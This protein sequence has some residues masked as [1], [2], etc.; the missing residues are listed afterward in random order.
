MTLRFSFCVMLYVF[1]ACTAKKQNEKPEIEDIP[2]SGLSGKE[3]SIAHCS[4]CHGYVNPELLPKSSWQEVLPAMGHRMGIYS[5][6]S[7][8]DSL[9]DGGTSGARVR[10]AD[11]FPEK[12][13]LA[14]EDWIQLVNYYLDNAPDT[15]PP[16]LRKSPIRIGL[17]H[18]KYKEIAVSHRP[19]LTSLVKILPNRRGIVYGDG[20]SGRNLL[21]FLDAD[22]RE[23]YSLPLQ[24]TP[25]QFYEKDSAIYLTTVGKGV[26]PTDA[27]EGTLQ[28]L[29]KNGAAPGYQPGAV[30]IQYLR[31][32]VSMAYGDLNQDGL[33]D[34]V[35]C[36]FGNQT[37]QLAWYPSNGRGGY[38]NKRILRE[39]PGAITAIV[40]DANRDGLLDIYVL[41]AQGDEGVFLYENQG[42]GTFREKRLLS[43]LPLNGSQYIELADFNKDGFDDIVYVCGDNADKTPIQKNYHGI[44]IYLN[45]GKSN[46][47]QSYFYPLNGAYK[48]MVRDYDL[49][50]DLDIAA[51]SFFPDYL[52]YPE[53]SFIYLQNKGNLKFDDYSFPEAAKGR[54]V[55]MDAGDL[56][57]DGDV[58]LVLGSFVYF[59]PQGDTTGLG[60]KWL[61]TSPSVIVLENTIR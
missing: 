34:V 21:T 27:A 17:K 31:R 60:K 26:F 19:A 23:N 8:P 53:E 24:S 52:R 12:P 43:F 29:T 1:A 6:G 36:E 46:F 14:R 50:G 51:I 13:I 40:K 44:Y 42:K 59:L 16:P 47:T 55:V 15:I 41:M 32:P 61:S 37:G 54:W 7:R 57:A 25:V 10:E 30:A 48:A 18:F 45:D 38:D 11:I 49:D 28:R 3:L 58:D 35:A 22:L 33:D 20:K 9:F 5:S 4:R 56:D 2:A 39:K